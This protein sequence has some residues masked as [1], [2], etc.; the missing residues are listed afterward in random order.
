MKF[1]KMTMTIG[2]I[3]MLNGIIYY[4]A[5]ISGSSLFI[6]FVNWAGRGMLLYGVGVG[7]LMR[8]KPKMKLPVSR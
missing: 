6:D 5:S 7:I 3:M 4:I 2:T 8:L 1:N